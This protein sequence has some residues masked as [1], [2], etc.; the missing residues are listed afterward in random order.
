MSIWRLYGLRYHFSEYKHFNLDFKTPGVPTASLKHF[1]CH[2]Q[3]SDFSTSPL[4][5]C[6]FSP[7]LKWSA[8]SISISVA[9]YWYQKYRIDLSFC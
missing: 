7:P 9:Q 3:S 1:L 5:W 8:A 4:L 2:F 6:Y